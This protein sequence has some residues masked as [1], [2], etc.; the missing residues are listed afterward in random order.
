MGRTDNVSLFIEQTARVDSH[1][2]S[3]AR[4]VSPGH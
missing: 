2:P 4:R 1:L 3:L